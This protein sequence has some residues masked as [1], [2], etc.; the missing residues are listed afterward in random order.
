VTERS[1]AS[2]YCYFTPITSE[3]CESPHFMGGTRNS[4]SSMRYSRNIKARMRC[5]EIF[6]R[7]ESG[8]I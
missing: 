3:L 2:N 5:G 7:D 8:R 6:S 1:I 4:K